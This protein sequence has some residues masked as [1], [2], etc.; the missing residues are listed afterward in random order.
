MESSVTDKMYDRPLTKE[1]ISRLTWKE[2]LAAKV[3][4]MLKKEDPPEG[5]EEL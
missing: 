2:Q 5:D 1:E 4:D 3:A